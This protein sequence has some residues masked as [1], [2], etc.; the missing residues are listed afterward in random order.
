MAVKVREGNGN[1]LTLT[2]SLVVLHAPPLPLFT[3]QCSGIL[4]IGE[5]EKEKE[6]EKS[7]LTAHGGMTY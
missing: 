4:T 7:K 5:K 6:K 2:P 3:S 1:F